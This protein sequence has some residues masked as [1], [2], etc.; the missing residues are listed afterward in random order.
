MFEAFMVKY[1]EDRG[2]TPIQLYWI[3]GRYDVS[4]HTRTVQVNVEKRLDWY[5]L[6]VLLLTLFFLSRSQEGYLE[7]AAS[8]SLWWRFCLNS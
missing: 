7:L 6:C 5:M 2:L 4:G 3:L 1:R 8:S